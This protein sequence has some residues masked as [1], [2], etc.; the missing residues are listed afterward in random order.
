MSENL[1]EM[2]EKFKTI[3][4]VLNKIYAELEKM[5]HYEMQKEEPNQALIDIILKSQKSIEMALGK[6]ED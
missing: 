1:V 3:P 4:D 5:Y 2:I 6:T